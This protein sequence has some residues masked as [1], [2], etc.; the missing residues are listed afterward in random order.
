MN[1][2]KKEK[3]IRHTNKRANKYTNE[4]T[5][6]QQQQNKTNKQG[7]LFFVWSDAM[8]GAIACGQTKQIKRQRASNHANRHKLM[9]FTCR[10]RRCPTIP[11]APPGLRKCLLGLADLSE[12]AVFFNGSCQKTKLS[13]IWE[14][15]KYMAVAAGW[16]GLT[17]S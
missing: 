7:R 12:G 11:K 1:K 6:K 2:Q 4:Q 5:K 15:Q 3:R 10:N 14:F 17:C 8:V 16:A 9:K 13:S